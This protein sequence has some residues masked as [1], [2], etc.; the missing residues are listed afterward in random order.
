MHNVVEIPIILSA[1]KNNHNSHLDVS[2]GF[3]LLNVNIFSVDGV[4]VNREL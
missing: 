3:L 2:K 1:V 4:S